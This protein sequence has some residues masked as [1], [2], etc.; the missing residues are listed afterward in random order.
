M[1]PKRPPTACWRLAQS[2]LLVVVFS[3]GWLLQ[4]LH[5]TA[6]FP[7]VSYVGVPRLRGTAISL[8]LAA[9]YLLGGALGPLAAGSLSDH[10]T[11]STFRLTTQQ[12]FAQGL[13]LSLMIVIPPGLVLA[14]TELLGAARHVN[15]DGSR[16]Q[17]ALRGVA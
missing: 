4:Y 9:S 7:A 11:R 13:H 15:H 8:Y 3:V 6:A 5:F 14:G 12:T 16:M 17:A 10:F 2:G 1:R